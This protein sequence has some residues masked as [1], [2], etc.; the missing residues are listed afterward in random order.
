M[1]TFVLHAFASTRSNVALVALAAC[2]IAGCSDSSAN[3]TPI[4]GKVLIDGKPLAHGVVRF[5]PHGARQSMGALDERGNF[6]L[7]SY[8]ADDGAVVGTHR[9]SIVA[10]EQIS[11]TRARWYAPKHYASYQTSGLTVEVTDS[12]EPVVIELTWGNRRG[13][14]VETD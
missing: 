14:F 7:G 9:V 5:A 8:E 10:R 1:A 11:E 13:P 3:W 2:L 6:T 12:S 4:T